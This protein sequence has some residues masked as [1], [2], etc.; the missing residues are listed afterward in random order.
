MAAEGRY[1]YNLKALRDFSVEVYSPEEF[2]ALVVY[3]EELSPLR[4]EFHPTDAIVDMA[5]MTI[6]EITAFALS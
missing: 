5:G 1:K 3:D 4:H 6:D 2:W